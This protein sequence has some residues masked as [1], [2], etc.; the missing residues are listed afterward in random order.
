MRE[1]QLL[2]H[3]SGIEEIELR[4]DK[5]MREMQLFKHRSEIEERDLRIESG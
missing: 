2:K 5:I 1:Y 3:Q 4:S